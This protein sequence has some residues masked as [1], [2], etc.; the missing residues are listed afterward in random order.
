MK[1][2]DMPAAPNHNGDAMTLRSASRLVASGG[3]TK[4]E[5]FA[6]AAMQGLIASNMLEVSDFETAKEWCEW[7]ADAAVKHA[8]ALLS[9]LEREE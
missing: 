7:T 6:M 1:N 2:A 3:M 9:R 5:M 8:D 4:R